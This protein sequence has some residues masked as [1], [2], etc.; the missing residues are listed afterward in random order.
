MNYTALIA[1]LE[2]LIIRSSK[3]LFKHNTTKISESSLFNLVWDTN[4]KVQQTK[5]KNEGK[6]GRE[7]SVGPPVSSNEL[8]VRFRELQPA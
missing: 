2:N 7:S 1:P 5:L 4:V 8:N 3:A 6:V